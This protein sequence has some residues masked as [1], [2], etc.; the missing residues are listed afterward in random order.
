MCQPVFDAIR[1]EVKQCFRD[2]VN[3]GFESNMLICKFYM[4]AD[5]Y[6]DILTKYGLCGHADYVHFTQNTFI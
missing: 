5:K 2:L 4:F 1:R 6:R 3:H